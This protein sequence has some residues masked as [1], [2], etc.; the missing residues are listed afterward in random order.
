MVVKSST[1]KARTEAT[2]PGSASQSIGGVS[3][4]VANICVGTTVLL[5][6]I[7]LML[8]SA[9]ANTGYVNLDVL[10]KEMFQEFDS[11]S[12]SVLAH[13]GCIGVMTVA[14]LFLARKL[15][16][17]FTAFCM[18]SLCLDFVSFSVLTHLISRLPA[19]DFMICSFLHSPLVL[20]CI[21]CFGLFIVYFAS[22]SFGSFRR[23][24][25]FAARRI[26]TRR[27]RQARMN[28]RRYCQYRRGFSIWSGCKRF[29]RSLRPS[30]L[31]QVIVRRS[32][33]LGEQAIKGLT[34]ACRGCNAGDGPPSP[35]ADPVFQNDA[36][37]KYL[38]QKARPHSKS[39]GFK[40]SE[41]QRVERAYRL[42]HW[43][44]PVCGRDDTTSA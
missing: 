30:R 28:V 21:A 11:R 25:A 33:S 5:H 42:Y 37:A 34:P 15:L 10:H 40:Q 16:S 7:A 36:W 9:F 13:F 17:F 43:H 35:T 2:A 24:K 44:V 32:A 8:C 18:N 23:R 31:F 12:I 19:S 22:T 6:L 3:T 29:F 39:K 41:K 20:L 14:L 27:Y 38:G 4:K 26:G 1:H